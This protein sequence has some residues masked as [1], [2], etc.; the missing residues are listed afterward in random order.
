[1][2]KGVIV[3]GNEAGG[4]ILPHLISF[5][6]AIEQIHLSGATEVC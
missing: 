5:V 6:W 1:M 4:Q 3:S 2:I